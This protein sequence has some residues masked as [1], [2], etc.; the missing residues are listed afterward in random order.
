MI[1][2]LFRGRLLCSCGAGLTR[3]DAEGGEGRR[4]A[5]SQLG[6]G[7]HAEGGEGRRESCFAAEGEEEGKSFGKIIQINI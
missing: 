2:C 4:G 5:A 6:R 3:R 1:V 7:S